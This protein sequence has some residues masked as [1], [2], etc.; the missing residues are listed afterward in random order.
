M[1]AFIKRLSYLQICDYLEFGWPINHTSQSAPSG[2]AFNYNHRSAS[3]CA[4]HVDALIATDIRVSAFIGPFHK[5]DFVTPLDCSPLQ[6]VTKDNSKA[7]RL[8]VDFSFPITSSVN[9]GISNANISGST[10]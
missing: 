6:I 8:V 1:E 9:S 4:T 7:K 10:H 2:V 3:Q 5:Q